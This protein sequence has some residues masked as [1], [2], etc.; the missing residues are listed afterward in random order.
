MVHE[1]RGN[2]ADGLDRPRL[3]PDRHSF[4]RFPGHAERP[5]RHRSLAR[6]VHDRWAT[7]ETYSCLGQGAWR[8]SWQPHRTRWVRAPRL[9]VGARPDPPRA[10][11]TAP[12]ALALR[13]R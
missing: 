10:R 9:V 12:V 4:R 11:P 7:L 13:A 2:V 3:G 6:R 1:P 5:G 8:T